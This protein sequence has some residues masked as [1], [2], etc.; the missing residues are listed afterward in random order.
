MSS[1]ITMALSLAMAV[2]RPGSQFTI[3]DF[4]QACSRPSLS[5]HTLTF[6]SKSY[7]SHLQR[8]RVP[9]PPLCLTHNL[10]RPAHSGLSKQFSPTPPA[11]AQQ[12]CKFREGLMCLDWSSQQ[13]S[14]A[15]SVSSSSAQLLLP[16]SH[17]STR[18]LCHCAVSNSR[19]QNNKNNY[20]L[21][22]SQPSVKT[23]MAPLHLL[24]T[25]SD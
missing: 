22:Q 18:K 6:L 25:F 24:T 21:G 20:I 8:H 14:S 15:S 11:Q 3:E 1:C 7:K 23:G 2:L 9:P 10:L 5:R 12:K 4:L 19:K 16:G 13:P 17:T